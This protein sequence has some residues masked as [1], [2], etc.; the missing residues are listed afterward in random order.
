MVSE[1]L[2]LVQGTLAMLIL[3][4]LALEPMHGHGITVRLAQISRGV[5]NVNAGSL[6]PALRRLEDAGFVS[7]EWRTSDNNRRARYYA[8]T[9]RGRTALERQTTDWNVQAAAITRIL[10]ARSEER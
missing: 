9:K 10:K 8:L 5:F 4:A 7:G 3:K 1:D 6:F 2:G